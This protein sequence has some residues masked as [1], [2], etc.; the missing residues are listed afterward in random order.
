MPK[1]SRPTGKQVKSLLMN[2]QD[3][4]TGNERIVVISDHPEREI[5]IVDML[6]GEG[7]LTEVIT[8]PD[9]VKTLC[10]GAEPPAA[11]ILDMEFRD[12][13][14]EL[15]EIINTMQSKC[16]LSVPVIFIADKQDVSLRLA[17]HRAG[18][19]RYLAK[20]V[21]RF[22]L[23]QMLNETAVLKP[24]QP[25]RVMLVEDDAA[26]RAQHA[27][28][29]QQAFMVVE[30]VADPLQA[31]ELLDSFEAEVLLVSM[32]MA[33]CS[34]PELAVLLQDDER[35]A[36][37]PVVYLLE[38]ADPLLQLNTISS[39]EHYVSK[40]AQAA[41]LQAMAR[42]HAR[43]TRGNKERNEALRNALYE[44]ERQ[45]QALDSH[46][47]VS[48]ANVNG[49]IIYANEKFCEVSGYTTRELIGRNH[50]IIKSGLHPKEFFAEMWQTITAGRIW[51]GE[52]CNRKKNGDLYWVKTSVVPFI[53]AFGLPYQYVSIRT[54]ISDVKEKELH[55]N[56]S[57][58][59]ANI[60]S[61][62]WNIRDGGLSWS[63]S[64]SRLFGHAD[65]NIGHTYENF[66][67]AIH[68][69][70]LQMVR[71]AIGN[72]VERGMA[73]HIEHRCVWP[74]GAVHWLLQS[75]DVVRDA[76]GRPHHMLGLVQDIT[77]RKEAELGLLESNA[78]LEEAQALARMGSWE[79]DPQSRNMRWSAEMYRIFGQNRL[80]FTPGPHA[81]E[82]A[83]HPEDVDRL[84]QAEDRLKITGNMDI[85]YR[86]I[87]GDGA[88]R[89]V[90]ELAHVLDGTK[91]GLGHIRG[92]LQD[93]TEMKMAE[94]A[95]Q[96]AKEAAESASQAKSE[97]LA[98]MSHELRTPLNAI[99]GFA[100]LF[101]LD[102]QLPQ[103]VRNN[104]KQI[105]RAGRHLLSLVNDMID[106]ARIE[107]G[108]LELT[109]QMVNLKEVVCDS[110][111]LVQS[112][113]NDRETQIVLMQCGDMD[114]TLQADFN[115]LR[116]ALIN[117]LT[118]AI[119]YN[120]PKGRIHV[121]CEVVA[122]NVHIAI[123]DSGMGIPQEKQGRIFHAFDRLGEERGK[124][125]GTGIG[126]VIT[127]S[128]VEAMGGSIG[129]E[130][131]EGKGSTFWMEFALGDNGSG[132]ET[133]GY[134]AL[135]KDTEPLSGEAKMGKRLVLYIED[136]Q[137]NMRLMQQIFA[138]RKEWELIGAENAETGI[139]MA[140]ANL[141]SI[142][143]MDINLPGMDGF[144][145]LSILREDAQTAHI[146][147]V[148]LTAN[149]MKGDRERGLDAGF[150][151]YLTKPLDIIHL[152]G[153]MGRLLA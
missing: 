104:S 124:V 151:D 5:E 65:G 126:L 112:L 18:A 62:D 91:P 113:A 153:L 11:V 71:E 95:M 3:A 60:G 32:D 125:E 70:D 40:Q 55:L 35:K 51:H 133:G 135:Q 120:R 92:T 12:G 102:A 26:M 31:P 109:M 148:A 37:L 36:T 79:I 53:D 57:Q 122:G 140:R 76:S 80:R 123:T 52:V 56:R 34:G 1:D 129:F 73:Y 150:A 25:Y 131:V 116:Q 97:F 4:N 74:N 119:K 24:V 136:N 138:S 17:A 19:T 47:I 101:S 82:S 29:L 107:S 20:P 14:Q 145:A 49:E 114:I 84:L 43:H 103:E 128:L 100:Q 9:S 137:M 45:Q 143:L 23:L 96:Q 115:R 144:A 38:E 30:Q 152:M 90:H 39:S 87:R 83:A 42:R 41:E 44:L 81:F 6:R 77:A 63:D 139:T 33:R 121:L 94:Q 117:L 75:G 27:A 46:A 48:V 58:E 66:L 146:P 50:R 22:R 111:N 130:S 28:M 59:F 54:D 134:Q 61:W 7:Y 89:Y 98:S 105:E 147:V 16:Q 88:V 93:V 149:A 2:Q 142:I 68:P 110:I 13:Y 8:R 67:N 86:I 72:C 69:E 15:A 132:A 108:R 99:L 127:K 78:L 118:N 85:V 21:S 106:L 10:E 141:P 64:L